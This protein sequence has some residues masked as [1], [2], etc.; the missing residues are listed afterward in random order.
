MYQQASAGAS[1][2]SAI[3]EAVDF[4]KRHQP[5]LVCSD[6]EDGVGAIVCAAYFAATTIVSQSSGNVASD[7]VKQVEVRRGPLWIETDDLEVL[8]DYCATLPITL[9]TPPLGPSS[10]GGF[11]MPPEMEVSTKRSAEAAGM[12]ADSP[13]ARVGRM[14][15]PITPPSKASTAKAQVDAT[16][17]E[18]L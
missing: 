3:T 15:S 9:R 18:K 2:V 1:H 6:R 12:M 8:E 17:H 4:I 10:R 14:P 5:A 11:P 7:G 13:V 16:H